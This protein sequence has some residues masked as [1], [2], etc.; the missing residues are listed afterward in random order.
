[1]ST[2]TNQ[3]I[4]LPLA[5]GGI[6]NTVEEVLHT[7]VTGTPVSGLA[8]AITDA[9]TA[10]ADAD[11]IATTATTGFIALFGSGSGGTYAYSAHQI[12]GSADTVPAATTAHVNSLATII[13]TA[14]TAILAAQAAVAAIALAGNGQTNTDVEL[15]MQ[16][17]NGTAATGLTRQKAE[18]LVEVLQRFI[19][20]GGQGHQGADVPAL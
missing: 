18:L 12:T 4:G 5:G 7:T 10:L 15:R 6:T 3:Y 14:L 2:I 19:D 9:A 8:T 20:Q 17:D 1:M 11:L 16:I 13:N